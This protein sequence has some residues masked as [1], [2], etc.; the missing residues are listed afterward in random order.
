MRRHWSPEVNVASGRV[1]SVVAVGVLVAACATIEIHR[2][3]RDE[4]RTSISGP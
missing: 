2:H 3:S 1:A 4:L